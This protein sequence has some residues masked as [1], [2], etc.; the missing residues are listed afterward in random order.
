[1]ARSFAISWPERIAQIDNTVR[2]RSAKQGRAASFPALSCS[3]LLSAAGSLGPAALAMKPVT[4][5]DVRMRGFRDRT[6]VADVLRLLDERVQPL[7]A[8][9]VPTVEA[10][11]RAL[12]A[13]VQAEFAVP[14]FDRS[15]M[16]G[17]A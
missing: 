6:E 7:A 13:D 11:G 5:F 10:C 17:Y 9:T 15:A 14:G 3:P 16:D 1:M 4:F 12:A 2:A 8:E